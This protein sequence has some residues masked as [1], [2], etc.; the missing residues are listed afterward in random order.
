MGD[1]SQGQLGAGCISSEGASIPTFI[2]VLQKDKIV[3]VR[4]GSFSAALSVDNKLFLWGQNDADS[5]LQFR[6]ISD[7][8]DLQISRHGHSALITTD[9]HIYTWGNHNDF[10]QLGHGDF[11]SVGAPELV[12]SLY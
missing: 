2:A 4:A 5:P 1:N 8:K 11:S 3:A 6:G 10:G 9:G 12:N 7:I